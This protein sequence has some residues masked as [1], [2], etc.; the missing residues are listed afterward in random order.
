MAAAAGA[1]E[2]VVTDLPPVCALLRESVAANPRQVADR[3]R[4]QP[5]IWGSDIGEGFGL[6]GAVDVILMVCATIHWSQA[7]LHMVG[8]VAE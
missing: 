2:V 8:R 1:S 4:V 6:S 5:Y 3:I 7:P